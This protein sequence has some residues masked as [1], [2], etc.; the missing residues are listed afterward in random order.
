MA[1]ARGGGPVEPTSA[2]ITATVASLAGGAVAVYPTET[3]YGLGAHALDADAVA[4][5]AAL[6]GRDGDKPIAVIVARR[7]RS[8]AARRR[9]CRSRRSVS[10]RGFWPGP[11]TLVLP[12]AAELP[13]RAH[14]RERRRRRPRVEPSRRTGA[15]RRPRRADHRDERQSRRRSRRRP[16]SRRRAATSAD[17][18]AT[19]TAARSLAGSG[20]PW[21]SSTTTRRAWC[22]PARYRSTTLRAMRS[23]RRRS[24]FR[25]T[26]RRAVA[27]FTP[28][29]GLRYDPTTV[30][31]IWR[32]SW[33]RRTT[34]STPREQA[35]ALRA[36]PH[37]V[38]RLELNREADPYADARRDARR[39]AGGAACSCA[40]PRPRFSLYAQRFTLPDGASRERVGV[41]GALRLES[42]R[43]RQRAPARADAREGE[44]RPAARC[45]A[46]A[47]RRCRRSS[48]SSSAPGVDASAMLVPS[49]SARR[50]HRG[51][52]RVARPRLAD[53]RS[54]AL[55]ARSP[56][57]SRGARGLHRRR[58][59]PLRD[60]APLSRR[61][62]RDA[63]R[64]GAA[65]G[66][67]AVRLRA[68][69]PDDDGRP[70][71]VD[72]ADASRAG[73]AC[74]VPADALAAALAERFTVEEL[75]ATRRRA[76]GAA[77][78]RL[79]GSDGR[80]AIAAS[81]SRVRGAGASWFCTA[82]TERVPCRPRIVAPALRALDVAALHQ[83]VLAGRARRCRSAIAAARPA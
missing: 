16:T 56:S 44:G 42:L 20:R 29:C 9:A 14:R 28:F 58:P 69:V 24:L 11:L 27:T 45:C 34:S 77:G 57:A 5:V 1:R 19:S 48:A 4:R 75:P 49:P 73:D 59:P 83:V 72:P 32:A 74:L 39:V 2:E 67:G 53:R 40:T 15:R 21:Y 68:H 61:D 80:G 17:G 60:R 76:R 37:N 12:G 65:A 35:S 50:R 31:A 54:R 3:F 55:G 70:G 81:A 6:K 10:W 36:S 52:G 41:I 64:G 47:G 79:D 26:E 8:G 63:R 46:P 43:V 33:R 7:R 66:S 62:A 82:P 78:T 18:L 30:A 22:G 51:R 25:P 23:V 71:L 13:R 38:I